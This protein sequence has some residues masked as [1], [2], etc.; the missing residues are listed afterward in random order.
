MNTDKSPVRISKSHNK[1]TGVTYVYEVLENHWDKEK[2]Y[3]VNKRRLIGRLDPVTG[4][5]IPTRKRKS[6]SVPVP[7]PVPEPAPAPVPESASPAVSSQTDAIPSSLRDELS[8]Q[9]QFLLSLRE[10]IDQ[11]INELDQTLSSL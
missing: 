3:P 4:E 11:R 1:K 10:Q 6:K 8:A 9:K 7:E 2:G 5:I